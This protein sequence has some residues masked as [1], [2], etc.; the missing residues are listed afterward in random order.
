MTKFD[1]EEPSEEQLRRIKGL[2]DAFEKA[3]Q[4]ISYYLKPCRETS[5]YKTKIEEAAM[6]AVKSIAVGETGENE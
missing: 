3:D 1:Y 5:L 4:M 2:R 6:W